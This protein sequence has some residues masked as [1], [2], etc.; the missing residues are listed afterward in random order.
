MY[1]I[2][3]HDACYGWVY[4]TR[5]GDSLYNALITLKQFR[6]NW[7]KT[8]YRLVAVDKHGRASIQYDYPNGDP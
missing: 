4:T 6:K 3:Q 2:Q 8:K 5:A 7:P 1:K